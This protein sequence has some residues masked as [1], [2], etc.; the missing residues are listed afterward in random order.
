MANKVT[1]KLQEIL[2]SAGNTNVIVGRKSYKLDA[3]DL[4][5]NA[6]VTHVVS[7]LQ[8]LRPPKQARG[9]ATQGQTAGAPVGAL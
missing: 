8:S 5:V 4:P 3:D 6:A 7:E 1:A 9:S 2:Q